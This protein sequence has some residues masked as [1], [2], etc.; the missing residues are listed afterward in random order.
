MNLLLLILKKLSVASIVSA[1]V[2]SAFFFNA[3]RFTFLL[4]VNDAFDSITVRSALYITVGY[5]IDDKLW[6]GMERN[7]CHM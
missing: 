5:L 7:W 1:L 4:N 3:Q 6:T 2:S